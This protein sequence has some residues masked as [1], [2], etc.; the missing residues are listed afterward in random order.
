MKTET[1]K[2]K[3]TRR[4]F[5]EG[6]SVLTLSMV[7]LSCSDSAKQTLI[8]RQSIQG[9]FSAKLYGNW[10][11]VYREKWQWDSV[12]KGAH[13]V[14]NCVS[15]CPFNVFVK[16][17]IVF[18]EE[19]N[20]IM[21]ASN[22]S[23][24][25]FNPRGCQK[26]NCISQAMYA[27]SRLK[28]P[29]RRVGERGEG[30]WKRISWD[31]AFEEMADKIVEISEESGPECVIYDSG[32]SNQGYGSESMELLA[33]DH[34][35]STQ[36]DGWACAGDMPLGVI[37][38]WGLF[39][40]DST[41]DDY[42]NS[43]LILL[44]IGNPSYTRIPDAHFMWEARYN[45][46]KVVSIAPDYNPSTMHCDQWLN[47]NIGSDAALALS[48]C[49][50]IID[51]GLMKQDYVKEQTDLPLL[52][53]SDNQHF[54]RE[55][56]LKKN[57]KDNIFYVWDNAKNKLNIAPG[58]E[59]L[60]DRT[61]LEMKGIDPSLN[62][63]YQIKLLDGRDVA[64]R[65]ML[66]SLKARLRD[67][68]PEKASAIVGVGA[69]TIR[70]LALDAG[71]AKTV[72][73]FGSWGIMKHH[74]SD[75][76]QRGMILLLAL[77]G[78]VGKRGAGLHIGAWY[79]MSGMEASLS[80][81]K[82]TWWQKA[83]M[84]VYQ[85][86]VREYMKYFLEYEEKYM[87]MNVPGLLFLYQWAGLDEVVN[88][89]HYH[90]PKPGISMKEAVKHSIESGNTPMYPDPKTGKKP[91]MYV[92][93]RVNPLRRWPKPQLARDNL[94]PM[95]ELIVGCNVKMSATCC[96]SDILLPAAHYYE[97][98]G[99][100]YA[101]SYV[102]YYVLGEKVVDPIGEAK[103]EWEIFGLLCKRVQEKSIAKNMPVIDDAKGK[104]KD[105]KTVFNKWSANG[106]WDPKDDLLYYQEA[107]RLS[108]EIGNIEWEDAVAQGAVHIE[109]V[110]PFRIHTSI[111]SDYEPGETVYSQ[112]WFTEKKMAW[113]T[114]T[115]RQ[116]FYLDH[117]WFIDADEHL[118]T[119]K[120]MPKAGGNYPLRLT[121]G[122]NRWSIH[123]SHRDLPSLLQL[124]RGEPSAWVSADDAQRRGV[125]DGDRI[126][127]FNDE[128]ETTLLA[129]V[130]PS[131]KPGQ[132]IIYHAWENFQF[133]DWKSNQEPVPS[134]W[135][136]LHMA[137]Y[138]QLHYRWLY[139]GPHHAP[140]G[141]TL[142]F[143]KL[144]T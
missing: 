103:S 51:E 124:Q 128:G 90:D 52:V 98:R 87:Y 44:W 6:A 114:L 22:D 107:T 141:T 110:G 95:M 50:V 36:I 109:D 118:P 119:H 62:G 9:R 123:S 55:S 14:L 117:D 106:K 2:L 85:P 33:F 60:G 20:A 66:E 18:R 93:T 26:G 3:L 130:S 56:D 142:D 48:M 75:L 79:M 94:F 112:Q 24:P 111:C 39:N 113:P 99:I 143:E 134:V 131:V 58:S 27:P 46:S 133:K 43:E 138:G 21:E 31:E 65:P 10:Q 11:D 89:P 120:P 136:S 67:Y 139:G 37:M 53:R 17:G 19:Q 8:G 7:T 25:D 140:R 77:T 1:V 12:V 47:V 125:E 121:G 122:H 72:S 91:R 69:E 49:K 42:F 116:Q 45:G 5:L 30:K 137:T 15:A 126:R 59:G 108:P 63:S 73:I 57:G 41:S 100:K 76:Y 61:T 71:K 32:T 88:K 105:L 34:L 102:P 80:A 74:H 68:T 115:G 38:T 82:P 64:V 101:Q 96:Y 16:D 144:G 78:N 84:A 135:K 81:V 4:R 92:H 70:K 28:Y 23:Y 54:L 132:V 40:V 83:L 129:K 127:C 29:L 97:R 104:P 13:S 86:T 35:G